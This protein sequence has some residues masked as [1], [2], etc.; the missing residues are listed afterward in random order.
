MHEELVKRLENLRN[1]HFLHNSN[2]SIPASTLTDAIAA[3][4]Q[5]E[6]TRDGVLWLVWSNEHNAWWRAN[7]AGYT[8][9]L[10][11]AGRYPFADAFSICRNGGN[12]RAGSDKD[13]PY[14]VMVPAPLT[15]TDIQQT[16]HLPGD[17]ARW[18]A[19]PSPTAEPTLTEVDKVIIQR[20]I[21][22]ELDRRLASMEVK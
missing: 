12:Q 8:N 10:K 3:L 20:M 16:D 1:W 21:D 5:A 11:S 22:R 19:Q 13:W 18:T 7:R 2:H 4:S 17:R 9:K 14:E 6:V 15:T